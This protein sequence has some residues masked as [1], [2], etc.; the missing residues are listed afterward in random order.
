MP[1][2]QFARRA[3]EHE[4]AQIHNDAGF[5]RHSHKV[6]LVQAAQ[7][8]MFPTQKRFKSGNGAIFQTHNRLEHDFHFTT[9]KRAA[10]ICL[11]RRAV[12]T[13]CPHG[14][15]ED[16]CAT[17]AQFLRVRHGDFGILQHVFALGMQL[18]IIKRNAD[19]TGQSHIALAEGN[20][21]RNRAADGI[22]NGHEFFMVHFRQKNDGEL[23]TRHA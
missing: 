4:Y 8:R 19:R 13:Q 2:R 16:F 14:G 21:G 15:A 17:A 20:G 23:I 5:F 9:I 12:G 1:G 22:G 10:Q 18:H 11:K 6:A 3:L 7:A